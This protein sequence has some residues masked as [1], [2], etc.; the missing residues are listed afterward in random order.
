MNSKATKKEV[1]KEATKQALLNAL[2]QELAV[3][4][5]LT[6][7]RIAAR[8]GVNKTLVYRYFD[9]LNGLLA[10]FGNSA[11]FMPQVGEL[12]DACPVDIAARP[13]VERFALCVKAYVAALS[14]RPAMVQI[15]LR[16][17]HLDPVVKT[18]LM[19]GRAQHI[20]AVRAA[21]HTADAD[22]PFDLDT[23]FNLLISGVCV[24]LANNG[25]PQAAAANDPEIVGRLHEVIDGMLLSMVK[26][27]PC[28]KSS[29]QVPIPET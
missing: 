2:E 1:Q 10:A 24:L 28:I 19:T 18:A 14:K 29:R 4:P 5:R 20:E 16:F 7:E 8:A 17:P 27:D 25:A 26:Q 15:L 13:A 6:V 3:A 22:L 11:T 12:L 9:G 23:T 21:F